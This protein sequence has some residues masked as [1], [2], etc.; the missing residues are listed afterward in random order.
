MQSHD[1]PKL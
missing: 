1:I